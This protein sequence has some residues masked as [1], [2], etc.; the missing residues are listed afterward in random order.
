MA[1]RPGARAARRSDGWLRWLATIAGGALLVVV[2]FG[3]GIVLGVMSEEPAIVTGHFAGHGEVVPW[4]V[5]PTDPEPAGSEQASPTA[6]AASRAAPVAPAPVASA[7]PRERAPLP[8]VASAPPNGSY[9]I[10]IGAFGTNE[11]A[12]AMVEKLAAKGHASYVAAGAAARDGRWRVRIGPFATR[13]EAESR[14]SSIKQ[15]EKLPTWVLFEEGAP[16]AGGDRPSG[17]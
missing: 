16:S 5:A 14:A 7:P 2:A 1:S 13:E 17:D 6:V 11:A 12:R 3:T 10:Q 4:V 8:P 9:A 15:S